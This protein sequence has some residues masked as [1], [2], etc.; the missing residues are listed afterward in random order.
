MNAADKLKAT[1]NKELENKLKLYSE[2]DEVKD[3]YVIH[4]LLNKDKKSSNSAEYLALKLDT[5]QICS[6][7]LVKNLKENEDLCR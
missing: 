6:I 2:W 5:G 4:Q 3:K 1:L 7:K